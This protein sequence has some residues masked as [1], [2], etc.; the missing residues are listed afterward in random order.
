MAL[1]LTASLCEEQH[2]KRVDVP[3]RSPADRFRAEMAS[4]R[5]KPAA[6]VIAPIR[7]F[8]L[9]TTGRSP[10]REISEGVSVSI[11]CP[12]TEQVKAVEAHQARL[13]PDSSRRGLPFPGSQKAP[14]LASE[15]TGKRIVLSYRTAQPR[16][17]LAPRL[18]GLVCS[19]GRDRMARPVFL[20]RC[21]VEMSRLA[22]RVISA[23]RRGGGS[24]A[25]RSGSRR[26]S[27]GRPA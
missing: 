24:P 6:S 19:I 9:S 14:L 25:T 4:G 27:A 12:A 26:T 5:K 7:V 8:R 23:D 20:G 11:R 18:D 10:G 15:N 21:P 13:L 3:T 1:V 2:A 22:A 16:S 17:P